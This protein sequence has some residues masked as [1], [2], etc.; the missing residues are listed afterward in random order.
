MQQLTERYQVRPTSQAIKLGR[1]LAIS[2]GERLE[3]IE[4]LRELKHWPDNKDDFEY[5]Q[6][7]GALEFK[8]NTKDHWVRVFIHQEDSDFKEMVILHVTCK[9]KNKLVEVD[10]IAVTSALA[11]LKREYAERL[12]LKRKIAKTQKFTALDGGKK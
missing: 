1:K 3:I 6:A 11:N 8:F 10:K 9:K 7:F 4:H 5:E 2:A 12:F